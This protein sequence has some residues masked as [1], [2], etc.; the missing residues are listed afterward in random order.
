MTKTYTDCMSGC[1]RVSIWHVLPSATD[2]WYDRHRGRARGDLR[3]PGGTTHRHLRPRRS[4]RFG[5][6][7]WTCG[8]LNETT[9][10]KSPS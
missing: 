7:C 2:Q 9:A 8:C 3:P 1:V 6:R 5:P 10:Y 4:R